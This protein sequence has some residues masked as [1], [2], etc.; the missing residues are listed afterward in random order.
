MAQSSVDKT[1]LERPYT[2]FLFKS[3]AGIHEAWIENEF[4]EALSQAC[5]LVVFLPNDIKDELWPEK[6]S[7]KQEMNKAY[8]LQGMDFYTTQLRRNRV[9]KAVAFQRLEPFMDKM[10]RLLDDKGWL[11][12]GS[13]RPRYPGTKKLSVESIEH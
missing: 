5:K 13:L 3:L 6:E 9:A 2:F 12:R 10:V 1:Q 8:R 4:G 7:I 11:E